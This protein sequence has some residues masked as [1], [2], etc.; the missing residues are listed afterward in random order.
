M[1][2]VESH[3]QQESTSTAEDKRRETLTFKKTSKIYNFKTTPK[4]LPKVSGHQSRVLLQRT[5]NADHHGG[6]TEREHR[7]P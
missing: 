6:T 3:Q 7:T 1:K 2:T 4:V 5:R